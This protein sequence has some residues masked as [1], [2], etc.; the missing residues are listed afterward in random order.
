MPPSS[1]ESPIMNEIIADFI[2]T[3]DYDGEG[4]GMV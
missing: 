1:S 4:R 2:E 3:G